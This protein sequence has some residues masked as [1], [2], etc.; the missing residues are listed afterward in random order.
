[1][2]M[3]FRLVFV[4]DLLNG[5]VVHAIRGK[6]DQYRPIHRFSTV[7]LASDPIR[8][9]EQLRPVEVYLADL[10]RLMKTGDN[11]ATLT[12][13]RERFPDVKIMLEYGIRGMEDL[14]TAAAADLADTFVLG[15][16]TASLALIADASSAGIP[17]TVSLDLFNRAVLAEDQTLR[18][19]PLVVLESL[20]AYPLKDLIVLELNRVGTKSGLD[21]EFLAR[22]AAISE[23]ALL[24]GGGVRSMEDLIKLKKRGIAGALVATAVHDGSIPITALQKRSGP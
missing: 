4:L 8:I 13:L 14:K 9:L 7:V 11:R 2:T 19:D 5:E 18:R 10:N 6:R 24:C 22:A 21:L 16:E 23:H 1:M 12:A 15:T 17:V 3:S 20:N